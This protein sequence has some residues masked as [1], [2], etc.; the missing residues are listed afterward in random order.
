MPGVSEY[1]RLFKT[2]QIGKLYFISSSHAR[3][4]SFQIFIIPENEL[5]KSNDPKNP[6]LN[7][8]RVEVYG[9]LDDQP[10]G[11]ESYGWLHQGPW[12]DDFEKLVE[13]KREEKI[14]AELEELNQVEDQ[15]EKE[16]ERIGKLLSDY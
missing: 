7:E 6:L 16:A 2:E 10:G 11:T 8:N 3:G 5:A 14:L 4:K 9:E 1:A 15:K 13:I 12:V